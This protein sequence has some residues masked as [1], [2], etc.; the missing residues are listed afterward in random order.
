MTLLALV[1]AGVA[2]PAQF[3]AFEPIE[4]E[5]RALD[6]SQFLQRQIELVLAT[7]GCELPQHGGRRHGAGLQ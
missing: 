5:Q 1:E 4:H 2:A 3:W 6:S 7:V